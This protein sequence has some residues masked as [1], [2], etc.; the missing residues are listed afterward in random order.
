M[1]SVSFM[2]MRRKVELPVGSRLT[3]IEFECY[4]E[5]L[6]PFACRVGVCGACVME[7]IDGY[8]QLGPVSTSERI[9]LGDLGYCPDQY[10]LACQSRLLGDV[11]VRV[12][13]AGSR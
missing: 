1:P 12:V 6:I 13:K 10:R 11:T 5:N 9:F 4:G 8:A 3:D 2:P 7:V